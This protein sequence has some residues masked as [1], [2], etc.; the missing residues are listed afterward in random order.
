MS[1]ILSQIYKAYQKAV[2]SPIAQSLILGGLTVPALYL[3]NKLTYNRLKRLAQ[4][5][6]AAALAGLTP[7]EAQD[8]LD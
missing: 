3:T 5:P 8:S 6:R 7:K 4:D 1:N 2:P